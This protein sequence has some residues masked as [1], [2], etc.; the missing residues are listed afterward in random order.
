MMVVKGKEVEVHVKRARYSDGYATKKF[1]L[2][3]VKRLFYIGLL[4]YSQESRH[5]VR[6]ML[7]AIKLSKLHFP[8]TFSQDMKMT[9]YMIMKQDGGCKHNCIYC[10]SCAPWLEEAQL[11]TF[12]MLKEFNRKYHEAVASGKKPRE[13]DYQNAIHELLLDW[14]PDH[15]VIM[16]IIN[17][18]Q[19]HC[20][21][22]VVDKVF[23]IDTITELN[24]V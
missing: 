22:G 8:F 19:L 11:L 12:G 17:F 4:P 24:A 3:G 5:N 14:Y 21:L 13:Q 23:I 18:P 1:K 6:I 10:T 2:G 16:D 9:L 20:L 15:V 7:Q